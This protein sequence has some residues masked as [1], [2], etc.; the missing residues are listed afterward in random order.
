[1]P[2][3]VVSFAVAALAALIYEIIHNRATL[4]AAASAVKSDFETEVDRAL[5]AVK[6]GVATVTTEVKKA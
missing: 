5:A 1:V 6:S 4:E 3:A 2:Y